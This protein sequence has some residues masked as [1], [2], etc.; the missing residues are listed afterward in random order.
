VVARDA[1]SLRFGTLQGHLEAGQIEFRAGYVDGL[2]EFGTEAWSR[3]GDRWADVLYS[4]LRV[5]KEIQ[6]NMWVHFCL[7]AAAIAGGR[8]AGGV[9]IDTRGI[10]EDLCHDAAGR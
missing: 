8:V 2:L 1:T 10:A 6:F 4:R 5:A 7:R 9:V 3:A